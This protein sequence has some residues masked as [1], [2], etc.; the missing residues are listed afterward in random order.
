MKQEEKIL[1]HNTAADL[2]GHCT[3]MTAWQMVRDLAQQTTSR[4]DI[5]SVSPTTVAIAEDGTFVLTSSGEQQNRI[6]Q[7][8]EGALDHQSAVWSL[9]ATVFFVVMGC[10]VMNG[11]G[12]AGQH[13]RSK[14]PY[15][16]SG[17]PAL[18]ELVQQCL[19]YAPAQRPHLQQVLTTAEKQCQQWAQRVKQGPAFKKAQQQGRNDTP[20]SVAFWPEE[21]IGGN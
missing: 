8:P 21:M 20:E 19:Q 4:T 13:A 3:E 9:G 12:G 16:R 2:S 5:C 14:V 10:N 18:S 1:T 17:M 6:Y 7:A 11:K 15:M